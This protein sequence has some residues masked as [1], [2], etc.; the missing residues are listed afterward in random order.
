MAGLK[1]RESQMPYGE[2]MTFAGELA[3]DITNR[4][5]IVEQV[6]KLDFNEL[7]SDYLHQSPELQKYFQ[8]LMELVDNNEN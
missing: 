5:K 3:D 6:K 2:C 4:W 8:E 7:I 1:A